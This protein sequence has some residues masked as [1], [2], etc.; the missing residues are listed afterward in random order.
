MAGKGYDEMKGKGKG[1]DDAMGRDEIKGKGYE[2]KS[3]GYA[4]KRKRKLYAGEGQG[5]DLADCLN[6]NSPTC[7]AGAGLVAPCLCSSS[8]MV[9]NRLAVAMFAASVVLCRFPAR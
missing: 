5:Q 3:K 9:D 1:Y 8:H 6:F 4:T 7:K 2:E